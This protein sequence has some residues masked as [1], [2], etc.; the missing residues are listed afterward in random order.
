MLISNTII[1]MGLI[2]IL[3]YWALLFF[4]VS[5]WKQ[6]PTFKPTSTTLPSTSVAIIISAR[7]EEEH[8][9]QCIQSILDNEYPLELV[10]IVV[11]NDHSTDDT[12]SIL[13][14]I[15]HPSL[16]FID[17]PL[18]KTGKK[19]AIASAIQT[20]QATL[21][22][23]TDAD[24]LVPQQWIATMVHYFEQ[25]KADMIAA[26]VLFDYDQTFLTRFQALDFCGLMLITGAGIAARFSYMNNGANLAYSRQAFL[27]VNGFEGVDDIASG[28]DI[29]LLQKFLEKKYSI[30]FLKSHKASVTSYS[31]R[32]Y[33][34]FF[35]QR[36]RWAAKSGRLQQK[37]LQLS[38]IIVFLANL[39]VL[40][41][42]C[43]ILITPT[44]TYVVLTIGI[45]FLKFSADY[46]LLRIS[47]RF[48]DH[49]HLLSSFMPAALFNPIY[50]C[51]VAI[52][53]IFIKSHHWKGRHQR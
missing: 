49:Q 6:M 14:S 40:V 26:P 10:E 18:G 23:T 30:H 51:I 2:S 13:Q 39:S 25:E 53:S 45:L 29:L 27:M 48:F 11:V 8:I 15:E 7:N 28:D 3:A 46:F 50:I 35:R 21:V 17:L 42:L 32:S 16:R 52:G 43:N 37:G 22:I 20:S 12:L 1:I 5:Y 19:T 34:S 9:R 4:Y 24:V 38:Q 31:Q 44:L 36:I 47:S 41:T 33:H